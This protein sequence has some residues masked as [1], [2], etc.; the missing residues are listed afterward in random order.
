MTKKFYV[1]TAIDYIDDVMHIGHAYQKIVADVVARYHRLQGEKVFFLTG[2]D[3]HGGKAEEAAKK[4]SIGFKEWADKISKAD[5]EQFKSLNISYDRFIRTTDKDHEKCVLEFWQKVDKKGDIYLGKYKGIYCQGCEGFI[6]TKDLVDG[7]CPYHPTKTPK[8][9]TEKNYFF[10]WS[11]YENFLRNYIKKNPEFIRPEPKRNEML[12]FLSQGLEDIPISRP[13]VEWGIPVPGDPKH[14]IYVWFDALINYLSGA[15]KGFWPAD[16]HLLGKDNLRWHA[17]LWPAMLK[18]AGYK[19][20]KT[21]YAHDFFTF[22]GQKISKS[23]GN[24]VRPTELVE[25]FGTD[26]VRYYFIKYGPISRDVDL[27][28][29][30]LQEVYNADLA[31]GLG[32]LVARVA[33]LCERSQITFSEKKIDFYK[34]HRGETSRLL[35]EYKFNEALIYIWNHIRR[36]DKE[37]DKTKPWEKKGK[38]LEEI[39]KKLVDEIR[40]INGAL[41]PFLPETAEKIEKQFKGPK[42]K[43]EKHLFPRIE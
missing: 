33:K 2:V 27:T 15:P 36:L 19:L 29:E 35:D 22:N 24:V 32:N 30:K 31:N 17:L 40:Q 14:T 5:K 9:L 13:S 1:T 39:L 18:S 38:S 12:A 16:L 10:R 11:K 28:L 25:K 34:S 43:S 21:V 7:K 8:K 6:T 26:G 23:L 4:A 20:P 37:I 42:I 3:E 41:K